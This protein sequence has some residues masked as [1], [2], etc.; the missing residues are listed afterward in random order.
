MGKLSRAKA[1][2]VIKTLD[3]IDGTPLPPD[4]CKEADGDSSGSW[5]PAWQQRKEYQP[6]S[7]KL[8]AYTDD[9]KRA[10]AN[11]VAKRRKRKGYK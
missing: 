6:Q 5:R 10:F 9:D 11:R 1:A 2:E 3:E 7:R 8:R 4:A